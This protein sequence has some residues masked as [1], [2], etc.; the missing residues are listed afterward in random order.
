MIEDWPDLIY[1]RT[2]TG[3]ELLSETSRENGI[4]GFMDDNENRISIDD[5]NKTKNYIVKKYSYWRALQPVGIIIY[6]I[7]EI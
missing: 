3:E 1:Q 5:V 7:K 6:K 2:L 4:G